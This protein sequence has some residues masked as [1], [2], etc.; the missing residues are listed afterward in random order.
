MNIFESNSK[1]FYQEKYISSILFI[2]LLLSFLCYLIYSYKLRSSIAYT[3]MQVFKI[4]KV[5]GW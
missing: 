1:S 3:I 2:I 4:I 5:L